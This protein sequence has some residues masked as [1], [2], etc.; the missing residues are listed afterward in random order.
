MGPKCIIRG[1]RPPLGVCRWSIQERGRLHKEPKGLHKA[2]TLSPR[3]SY[4]ADHS[5]SFL[6]F[7]K[8]LFCLIL[9]FSFISFSFFNS[10]SKV[11]D[12]F[13]QRTEWAY[14]KHMVFSMGVLKRLRNWE[15]QSGPSFFRY[16]VWKVDYLSNHWSD[17]TQSWNLS[18]SHLTR[19]YKVVKWR[20]PSMEDDLKWKMT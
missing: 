6:I 13:Q 4:G 5:S 9:M 20:W 15:K 12:I 7:C 17:L 19:G 8:L 18:L 11:L 2:S 14:K 3:E 1:Q 16:P 10:K